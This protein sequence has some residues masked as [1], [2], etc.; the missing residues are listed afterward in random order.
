MLLLTGGTPQLPLNF[1][2]I[3][4]DLSPGAL[5]HLNFLFGDFAAVD[6]VKFQSA[7]KCRAEEHDGILAAAGQSRILAP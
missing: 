6:F 4:G 5:A 3:D 2:V 7:K 1:T